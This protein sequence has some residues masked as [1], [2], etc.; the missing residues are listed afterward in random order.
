MKAR[1]LS[2]IIFILLASLLS[3]EPSSERIDVTLSNGT[4]YKS[5]RITST[6]GDN[7]VIINSEGI[8]TIKKDD[9]SEELKKSIG[10]SREDRAK[11]EESESRKK[12]LEK[13]AYWGSFKRTTWTQ[14]SSG[15]V[16]SEENS[17][18]IIRAR[19]TGIMSDLGSLAIQLTDTNNDYLKRRQSIKRGIADELLNDLYE[20]RQWTDFYL[21]K[22]D[23]W[24]H[25]K[26]IKPI[27]KTE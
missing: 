1:P 6:E 18:F 14:I 3:A 7:I 11:K 16:P 4:V 5:A 15:I 25:I 13:Q 23:G 24:Y 19:V 9:L 10:W 17:R 8:T 20:S 26:E 21:E 2:I 12:E 22:V 27:E